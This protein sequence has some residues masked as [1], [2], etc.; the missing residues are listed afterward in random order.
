MPG[1]WY[2]RGMADTD[3]VYSFYREWLRIALHHAFGVADVIAFFIGIGV[4]VIVQFVPSW[5]PSMRRLIW[6][7]P[8]GV[9]LSDAL[10]RLVSAPYSMHRG[11][12]VEIRKLKEQL[13]ADEGTLFLEPTG[14]N[15][16]STSEVVYINVAFRA[17]PKTIV[18]RLELEIDEL[19][20][21][22]VVWSPFS[23]S[24]QYT[25]TW[26]FDLAGK[27]EADKTYTGRLVA[28]ADN[29]KEYHS[30]DFEVYL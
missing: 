23:A 14:N 11:Q 19:R 5:E 10:V 12:C 4:P 6:Q 8:L 21:E 13:H 16:T 1:T 29:G 27:E 28:T 26:R 18:T 3:T 7:I 20:V 25:D 30:R 22:P 9:F 24:P 17:V 2:N 15:V